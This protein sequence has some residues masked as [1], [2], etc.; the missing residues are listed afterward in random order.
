MQ[1]IFNPKRRQHGLTMI[2]FLFVAAILV[3]MAMLAMKLVPAYME[4]FAVKKILNSMSQE[5]GLK[6][7][8]NVEIRNDFSKRASVDY[9]TRV[10]AEDLVI[11]RT[12]G[13]PVIAVEYE[14]RTPLVANISL[15]VDFRASSDPA[16]APQI[17]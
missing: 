10:K 3:A 7:K 2:G 5:A 12:G 16:A 1:R 4:F 17:E 15:V 11:D 14:F 13:A 9:V 6:G 8:T